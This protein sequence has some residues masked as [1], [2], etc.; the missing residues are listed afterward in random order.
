MA[1]T[2]A[3]KKP[4]ATSFA[5][6]GAS[7]DAFVAA[8]DDPVKR[9]D[10]ES[11]ITLM[12][13]VSG[14]APAMWGSA[15]IGFGRYHY[16]YESGREG[17]AFVVGFSPRKAALTL[18]LMLGLGDHGELLGR[19]GKHTTG[20]GCLYVKRLADVDETVLEELVTK[21]VAAMRE[22]YPDAR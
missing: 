9:R 20:K 14:E 5:E 3:A 13:R 6:T 17:D 10:S 2:S 15:M 1:K 12:R 8:I 18:Y 21:S 4:G 11:L 19:L 22:K 7:V 16:K